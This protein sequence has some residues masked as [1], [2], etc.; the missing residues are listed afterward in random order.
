MSQV[1]QNSDFNYYLVQKNIILLYLNNDNN[2]GS[3]L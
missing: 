1:H 3:L 2:N